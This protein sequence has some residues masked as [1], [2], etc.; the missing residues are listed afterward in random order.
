MLTHYALVCH[1][2]VPLQ[3]ESD[4]HV[5]LVVGGIESGDVDNGA[6]QAISKVLSVQCGLPIISQIDSRAISL[7]VRHISGVLSGRQS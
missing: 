7:R 5:I 3:V 6:A 2:G 1:G 4:S